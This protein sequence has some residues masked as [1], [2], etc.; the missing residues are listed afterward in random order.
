MKSTRFTKRCQSSPLV[1]PDNAVSP[2]P[3]VLDHTRGTPRPLVAGARTH[4]L[5]DQA[6]TGIRI[7][8]LRRDSLC[9]GEVGVALLMADLQ[10]PE[11]ARMPLFEAEE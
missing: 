9:K 8:P 4:R 6:A 7:K 3:G 1:R 5:A 2:T 10:M 11:Q